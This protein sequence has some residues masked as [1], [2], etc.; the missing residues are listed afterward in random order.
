MAECQHCDHMACACGARAVFGQEKAP[1]TGYCPA[2]AQR[3]WEG[4]TGEQRITEAMC[5][6]WM[7][8]TPPSGS[9]PV[10]SPSGRELPS[11]RPEERTT[12]R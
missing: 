6:L 11:S 12:G 3:V 9:H 4:Q 10:R 1:D 2:C 7:I 8:C 5:H